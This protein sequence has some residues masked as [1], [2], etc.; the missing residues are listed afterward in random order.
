MMIIKALLLLFCLPGLTAPL[1]E[2]RLH[3]AWLQDSVKWTE[4]PRDVNAHLQS[5]SAT[6]MYFSEDHTFALIE[7]WVYREPGRYIVISHGDGRSVYLGKWEP[8]GDDIAVE[9]RLVDRTIRI[10][11]EVLPGPV[12]QATIKVAAGLLSFEGMRFR[13]TTK[14]DRSAG[15]VLN[16]VKV[17]SPAARQ[18]PKSSLHAPTTH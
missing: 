18:L 3:G 5:G 13:R 15:E 10:K 2:G 17:P 4:A 9:Y 1:D 11:G 14:L 7:C 6:V 8:K 16:G 12:Q